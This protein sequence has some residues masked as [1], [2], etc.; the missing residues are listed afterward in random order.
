MDMEGIVHCASRMLTGRYGGIVHCASRLL[1]GRYGGY[2][3]L[4][5]PVVNW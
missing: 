3:A 1:T 2:C 5:Q 4:C